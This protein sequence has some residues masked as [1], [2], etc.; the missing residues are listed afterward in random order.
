MDTPCPV[1]DSEAQLIAVPLGDRW[2][3][4]RRLQELSIQAWC[5]AEGQLQVEVNTYVEA[6]QVWSVVRQFGTS[7]S[8][9]VAWLETCWQQASPP[10]EH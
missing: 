9:L 3:I 8:T 4:R 7:R 1:S 2:S 6:V 10:H 5:P